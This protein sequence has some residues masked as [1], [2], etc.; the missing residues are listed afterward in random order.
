MR[1]I[2]ASLLLIA[3]CAGSI[4]TPDKS[5]TIT[6]EKS[7]ATATMGGLLG[8]VV[9]LNFWAEWCKPCMVEVPELARII[10]EEGNG[11]VF[12]PVY[13]RERPPANSGL[14]AWL[15]AQPEYFRDRVCWGSASLLHRYL[16]APLLPQTFVLGRDGT[17]IA[18]FKGAIT[19]PRTEQ[20][21]A[22][23]QKGNAAPP[24][25]PAPPPPAEPR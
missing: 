10:G 6:H 5:D 11:T 1:V 22:A 16:Q 15:G 19:G 18:Y 4:I 20:L 13:Y 14:Y 23:I 7:G 21:R 12:L 2:T 3:G 9:V 8:H 24:P 25:M 17:V